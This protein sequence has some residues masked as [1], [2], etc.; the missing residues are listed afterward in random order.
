M[1][2]NIENKSLEGGSGQQI[3][4]SNLEIL[5]KSMEKMSPPNL[6]KAEEWLQHAE[7]VLEHVTDDRDMWI[8]LATYRFRGPTRY[9][10]KAVMKANGE[11]MTWK[12]FKD[13]FMDKYLPDAARDRKFYEFMFLTKGGMSVSS[14][15]DKFIRLSHNGAELVATDEA[16][17]KKFIRGLDPEMRKQLSCLRI[18]TYEDALNRSLDYEKEMEDQ[19]A[20]RI[21]ER[22]QHFS[23]RQ[24][25]GKQPMF[26]APN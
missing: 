5:M 26:S 15:N 17:A 25:P 24:D 9:W 6:E 1:A 18:M 11:V 21:R 7:Y 14:Y 23:A 10:W 20:A 2:D 8:K 12:R 19:L 3:E 16:N 22:P 13:L 4:S